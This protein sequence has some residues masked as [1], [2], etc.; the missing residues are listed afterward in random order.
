VTNADLAKALGT[1]ASAVSGLEARENVS[2]STALR[3]SET[4]LAVAQSGLARAAVLKAQLAQ[5]ASAV[6]AA[7]PLPA[8][9]F[10]GPGGPGRDRHAYVAPTP[11]P[12]MVTLE[13][14]PAPKARNCAVCG[15]VPGGQIHRDYAL[16]PNV[17]TTLKAEALRELHTK[18]AK[19]IEKSEG[20]SLQKAKAAA[21]DR[22]P[23]LARAY[24]AAA[25]RDA[26]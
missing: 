15:Q 21:W 13:G 19:G 9:S 7:K 24:N 10:T 25:M 4:A 6:A 3:Y 14:A 20:I 8:S 1:S 23:S 11:D 18:A 17:G 5:V 22:N 2:D 16:A 12:G 26:S